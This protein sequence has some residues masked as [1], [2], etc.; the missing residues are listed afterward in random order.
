MSTLATKVLTLLDW[1]R[2]VDPDG[3][4]DKIVEILDLANPILK[5]MPFLEGNLPTGHLATVRSG[6]PDSTWRKLNWGVQPSKSRTVQVTE[7]IGMLAALSKNDKDLV[8]LAGNKA[9]F[10]LSEATPFLEALAQ[11]MATTLFYGNTETDP[12]KFMGLSPRYDSLSAENADNILDG[13]GTGSDNCSIWLIAWGP[14]TVSGIFPKGSKA[15][16]ETRNEGPVFIEDTDGGEYLGYK[17]WYQ[18]KTGLM[19]KDWRSVVRIC[20]IDSSLLTKDVSTG[21]DLI[22]LIIKALHLIPKSINNQKY[23][24][25][26]KQVGTYLDLQTLNNSNTEVGYGKT[27]HGEEIMTF[28]GIPVRE[29]EALLETEARV[30]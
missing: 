15:G 30:T 21:S 3:K 11:E 29:C 18:S 5:D 12:E 8:E 19:L 9:E 27:I 6:L 23:L 7:A 14:N 26:N 13:T 25:V 2:R 1:A 17:S 16:M 10:L 4:I 22:T 28:R 20:N 24:Y